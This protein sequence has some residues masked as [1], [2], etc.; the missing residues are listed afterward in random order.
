[1]KK[2]LEN[3]VKK[4]NQQVHNNKFKGM[5][6]LRG[7]VVSSPHDTEEIGAMGREIVS[8][9]GIYSVEA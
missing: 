1:L 5:S 8:R 3:H 6:S 2:A 4:I 9:Q 7:L